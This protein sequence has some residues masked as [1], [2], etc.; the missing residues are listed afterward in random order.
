MYAFIVALVLSVAYHL[1]LI[2][3][4]QL[5]IGTDPNPFLLLMSVSIACAWLLGR[6]SVRR[7]PTR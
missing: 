3:V 5:P 4:R 6:A 7:N 2:E 1:Y